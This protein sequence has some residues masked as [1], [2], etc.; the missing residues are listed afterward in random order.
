MAFIPPHPP[1]WLSVCCSDW[2]ISIILSSRS[3]GFSK[4]LLPLTMCS[5]SEEVSAEASGAHVVTV[6]LCQ[7]SRLQFCPEAARG[8][9]PS[10]LCLS[11]TSSRLGLRGWGAVAAGME[12]PMLPPGALAASVGVPP[13]ASLPHIQLQAGVWG[14]E[15][16]GKEPLCIPPQGCLV[17]TCGSGCHLVCMP[18][19]SVATVPVP[20]MQ[21][22]TACAPLCMQLRLYNIRGLLPGSRRFS[23][24]TVPQVVVFLMCLWRE[25]S[26]TS[27]Y[28]AI[29]LHLCKISN[30]SVTLRV[31]TVAL[32]FQW[33][34]TFKAK[35]SVGRGQ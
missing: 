34:P 2:V 22:L 30:R 35:M 19:K 7:W 12:V 15:D 31:G 4:A 28:S 5:V 20:H 33:Y 29:L 14:G 24:R 17:E 18:T 10:P 6:N 32:F 9:V 26:S 16:Q 27:F 8:R 1:I 11:Q 23:V 3:P 13:R 21:V 25:M